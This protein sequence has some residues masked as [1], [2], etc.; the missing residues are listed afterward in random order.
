MPVSVDLVRRGTMPVYI[1]AIG[2]VTPVYTVT[3]TSRIAGELM[4]IHYKEDQ[5]VEK[6]ELLARLTPVLSKP[7]MFKRKGHLARDQAQLANARI[8]F[9]AL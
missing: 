9:A 1:S 3:V 6:G 5:I 4:E 8:R 7:F 2:T